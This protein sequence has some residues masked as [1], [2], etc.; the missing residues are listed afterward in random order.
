VPTSFAVT[1]ESRA[2]CEAALD[3]SAYRNGVVGTAALG[4]ATTLLVELSDV[5]DAAIADEPDA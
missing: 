2:V 3:L 4:A 5:G 1:A